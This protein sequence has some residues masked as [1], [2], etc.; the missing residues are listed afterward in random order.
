MNR[1]S[2]TFP[3]LQDSVRCKPNGTEKTN[4]TVSYLQ[5]TLWIIYNVFGL[6]AFI[7]NGPE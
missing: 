7:A 6:P 2:K 1:S 3:A 4:S 5:Q